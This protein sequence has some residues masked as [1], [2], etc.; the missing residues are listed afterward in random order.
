M[1]AP[2]RRPRARSASRRWRGSRSTCGSTARAAGCT[3]DAA[4]DWRRAPDPPRP[5]VVRRGRLRPAVARAASSRRARSA[6]T[7]PARQAR[8]A[9][10]RA[11]APP[12]A[13]RGVR[14]RDRRPLPGADDAARAR[15]V[16]GVRDAPA[17]HAEARRRGSGVRGAAEAPDA[18]S[19][20]TRRSTRILHAWARDEWQVEGVE[21]VDRVRARACARGLD[22]IMRD[23]ARAR[24]VARRDV[25][26]ADRRRGRARVRRRAEH[27]MVRT[28]IV[29][30]QRVDHR[31]R[32]FAARLRLASRAGRRCRRSTP[33][34]HLPAELHTEY[35]TMDF[36]PPE[37]VRPLLDKI[38]RFVA[39]ARDACRGARCSQRLRRRRA[40]ARRAAR[41]G[42]RR[43]GCGGRRSRR[44]WAGSGSALVEHGLVSERL[45]RIAARPLRVR[46]RR[47]PT[48]ATSRSSTSTARAEQKARWL[49][50]LARGE[51]RSC[52]SMTEPEN[53]G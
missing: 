14:R 40:A 7:S 24:S 13:D 36:D 11:A 9:V 42:A 46:L 39:R 25:G 26:R 47:R 20:R 8:R 5:G 51:I 10:R 3:S 2:A 29:D 4:R 18:A 12:A 30:P 21:R 27:R 6:R 17:L 1:P 48:P 44:S 45:G 15:R 16:P 38:E 37:S 28:S 22:R 23:A 19:S 52:F 50:P 53:P 34:R 31:A 32:A 43:Q 33:S 41:E 35:W 49:E